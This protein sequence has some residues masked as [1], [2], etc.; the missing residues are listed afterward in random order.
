MGMPLF[1]KDT[2][3]GEERAEAL[4]S[5]KPIDRVPFTIFGFAFLGVN[6][7]YSVMD[8]Y[9][10]TLKSFESG[11]MTSDQYG[12][13]WLPFGG[14]PALGPAE[15]GAEV[16]WPTGEFSQCPNVEPA[17]TTEDDAW[18]LEFIDPEKLKTLGF[19]PTFIEVAHL[20]KDAG[21]PFVVPVYGPW[22]TAGNIV[23]LDRMCRWS[24]KQPD[25]AHHVIRYATDFLVKFM[26]IM[27]DI[28]GP[29]SFW[30]LNSTASAANVIISPKTFEKFVMP[31]LIE[32]HTKII[33]MGAPS[34]VFHLCGEQNL[35]YEFYPDVPLPPL[36]II[37]VSHEVEL[38]KASASFP[39]YMLLGN[40]EPALFQ[41][42]TA[43]EVYEK[44]RVA[45]EKGKKHERGFILAPGC[46]MPPQAIPHNVWM[47]AKASNDFGYYG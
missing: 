38:E 27:C 22:T 18:A 34:I 8:W 25:L 17:I 26:Q 36:S 1:H 24:V 6:V 2:M 41:V 7:G 44:C 29:A 33:D 23:G 11:Q 31:Y 37:S 40:I 46:E 19:V 39:D 13:M 15:L 21:L 5:G 14:Y 45:V 4:L 42:G 32:Y 10:D 43:D 47:M 20:I 9:S 35:N 12:A 28:V 30:P 3:S 16:V